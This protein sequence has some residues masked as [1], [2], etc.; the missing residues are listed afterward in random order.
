MSLWWEALLQLP[1]KQTNLHDR[2][3]Q[4]LGLA[5]GLGHVVPLGTRVVVR[6]VRP[7]A[8]VPLRYTTRGGMGGE[9]LSAKL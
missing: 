9:E 6:V 4:L 3:E 5:A 2:V 1:K 7:L 8:L